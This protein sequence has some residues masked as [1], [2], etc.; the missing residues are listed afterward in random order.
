MHLYA[1]LHDSR[2]AWQTGQ[3]LIQADESDNIAGLEHLAAAAAEYV[4]SWHS[5]AALTPLP[6]HVPLLGCA[7]QAVLLQRLLQPLEALPSVLKCHLADLQ[8]AMCRMS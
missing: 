4:G 2:T 7:H 3:P 6:N 1:C 8:L 5:A